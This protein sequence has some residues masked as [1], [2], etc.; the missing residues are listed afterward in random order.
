[1]VCAEIRAFRVR[2]IRETI[3]SS[4]PHL[5]DNSNISINMQIN[6][7]SMQVSMKDKKILAFPSNSSSLILIV[8]C[9]LQWLI[10]WLY[11]VN[12]RLS[13]QTSFILPSPLKLNRNLW[14]Y[15][16]SGEYLDSLPG[17]GRSPGE[18]N[19]YL[20][21]YSWLENSMD[22]GAWRSTVHGVS[23][24]RTWLSDYLKNSQGHFNVFENCSRGLIYLE[25]ICVCVCVHT[26]T[27]VFVN[28]VKQ[29]MLSNTSNILEIL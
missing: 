13:F 3:F 16:C 23:K 2:K 5:L 4:S 27:C 15:A 18:G 20:F 11:A 9:L 6:K 1:M 22:R 21:Q 24:S 17:S 28:Q 10:L 26:C 29:K 25:K 19:G 8:T 7:C 14:D 12:T